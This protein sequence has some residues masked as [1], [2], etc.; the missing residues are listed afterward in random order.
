M[1]TISDY[2]RE[3]DRIEEDKARQERSNLSQSTPGSVAVSA[4][5]SVSHITA[6][7]GECDFELM[8]K[9]TGQWGRWTGNV[10][11]NSEMKKMSDSKGCFPV[12]SESAEKIKIPFKPSMWL[13]GGRL[14]RHVPTEASVGGASLE[15]GAVHEDTAN[16]EAQH[17]PAG[18]TPTTPTKSAHGADLGLVQITHHQV[19]YGATRYEPPSESTYWANLTLTECLMASPC[20]QHLSS[21]KFRALEHF[22]VLRSFADQETI[23]EANHKFYSIFFVR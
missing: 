15:S 22:A 9:L 20:F 7:T 17:P 5:V 2:F 13:K 21:D 8:H 11:V 1:D 23:L 19:A 6:R 4:D 14:K 16:P 12:S 10:A 3:I 18:D